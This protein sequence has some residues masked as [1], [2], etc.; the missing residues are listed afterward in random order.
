[1]PDFNNAGG[2]LPTT[3]PKPPV[4]TMGLT[5]GLINNTFIENYKNNG[6]LMMKFDQLAMGKMGW[7]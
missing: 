5:S 1:M 6:S 2:R 3:S 4:L 7:N